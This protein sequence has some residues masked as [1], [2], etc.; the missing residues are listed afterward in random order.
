MDWGRAEAPAGHAHRSTTSR[1]ASARRSAVSGWR[2]L[3]QTDIDS[4]A[5]VTDDHQFIHVDEA[6]ALAETPFG[7]TIAHGFLTLS[8]L[9]AFGQ[10]ACRRSRTGGWA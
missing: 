7:G 6:R 1:P 5:D 10:E 2:E 4:F 3:R 8:L 9:S